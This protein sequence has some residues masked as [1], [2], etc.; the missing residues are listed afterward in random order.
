MKCNQ[1]ALTGYAV[2]I[3][4]YSI[5]K[6]FYYWFLTFV[7][8]DRQSIKINYGYNYEYTTLKNAKEKLQMVC[9]EV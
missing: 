6:N 4:T 9:Y 1:N 7:S 2:K 8:T 5:H 3:F